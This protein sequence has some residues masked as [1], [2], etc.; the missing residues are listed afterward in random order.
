MPSVAAPTIAERFGLRRT[1]VT[2]M[3]LM[4]TGFALFAALAD[5][6]GGYR[7]ALP[8]LLVLAL[9][10]GLSM[11]PATTAITSALPPEKQGVASALN[12]TVREMGGAMGIALLGSVLNAQYRDAIQPVTDRLPAPVA[13]PVESGIGGRPFPFFG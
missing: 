8:G 13:E 6:D 10:V 11:S 1:L 3:L 4:A 9:G 2:G 5:V 12:D 7:S